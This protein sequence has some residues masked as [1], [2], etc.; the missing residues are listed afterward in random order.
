MLLKE[1]GLKIAVQL[2]QDS[3]KSRADFRT[4]SEIFQNIRETRLDARLRGDADNP[5]N[6][7]NHKHC[8][9]SEKWGRN[10]TLTRKIRWFECR[11]MNK[12]KN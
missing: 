6:I 8:N 5:L 11:D 12:N 4:Q 1:E 9:F 2:G 10:W 7:T 3:L